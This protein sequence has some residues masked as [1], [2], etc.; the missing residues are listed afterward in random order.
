MGD[1]KTLEFDSGDTVRL[2]FRSDTATEIH[3]HGYDKE[4]EVPAGGTA[5][6]SFEANAEGIF[7]IEDHGT[8]ELLAKLQVNP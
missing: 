3:V 6:T 5:R 2:R 7:E 1:P 4:L 8:G